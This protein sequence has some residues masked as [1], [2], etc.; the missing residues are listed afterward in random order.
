VSPAAE[1]K[2]A[3]DTSATIQ[4]LEKGDEEKFEGKKPNEEIEGKLSR[5]YK[6]LT[7]TASYLTLENPFKTKSFVDEQAKLV[8]L[9]TET[10][11]KKKKTKEEE[12]EKKEKNKKIKKSR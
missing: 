2:V 5:L 3:N 10:Q 4:T 9:E 7:I 11:P 12:K 8:T 1:G 6:D